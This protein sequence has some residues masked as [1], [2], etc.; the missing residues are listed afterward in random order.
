MSELFEGYEQDFLRSMKVT[1]S[2]LDRVGEHP[3]GTLELI[4]TNRMLCTGISRGS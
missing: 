4:Q 2:K 1:R 3:A